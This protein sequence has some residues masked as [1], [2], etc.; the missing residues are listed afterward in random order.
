MAHILW[1]CLIRY[2]NMKWI[3]R[4]VVKIQNRCDSG[5]MDRRT[6]GEY[7]NHHLHGT[8]RRMS[9]W[10]SFG[11]LVWVYPLSLLCCIFHINW[12]PIHS[13]SDRGPYPALFSDYFSLK[14]S[15][16]TLHI[17]Y[18]TVKYGVSF[19]SSYSDI[20]QPLFI[21]MLYVILCYNIPY[22]KRAPLYYIDGLVQERRNSSVLAM[23]LHLSCTNPSIW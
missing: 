11:S 13:C 6:S 21:V 18:M 20:Y 2:A 17:S 22:Y 15:Q 8:L 4:V 14:Y 9:C 5:Q 7:N 3:R 23:E 10:V 12:Y 16:K 19:V 1:S